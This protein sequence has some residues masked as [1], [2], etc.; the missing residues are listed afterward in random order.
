[1]RRRWDLGPLSESERGPRSH[2]RAVPMNV[3]KNSKRV[4]L[5]SIHDTSHYQNNNNDDGVD[6]RADSKWYGGWSLSVW[7]Q[8]L[9]LPSPSV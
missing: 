4:S 5:T 3:D 2:T 6:K 7:L 8:T 9:A 1:M